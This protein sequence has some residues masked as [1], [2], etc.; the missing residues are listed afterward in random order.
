LRTSTL[1]TTAVLVAAGAS[2]VVV[3]SAAASRAMTAT[4]TTVAPPAPTTTTA[5]ATTTAAAAA[6]TTTTAG[7]T[8]TAAAAAP[9][10]TGAGATTTAAGATS[11]VAAAPTGLLPAGATLEQ[12]E[13]AVLGALGP[14]ADIAAELTPLVNAVPAGIP[15]PPDADVQEVSVY[16]YP[17]TTDVSS[18]WYSS[19][20]LVTSA[21]A[22]PDLLTFFQS[23][24]P[25]A[26]FVQTGDSVENE[27]DRQIRWLDYDVPAPTSAQDGVRVAIVDY[28]AP[29]EID[30]MQL[31]IDY[32]LDPAVT[33]IYSGWPG[34]LPLIE[35]V[36]V[37]DATMTT[38]N[39]GGDVTLNLSN[40]YSIPVAPT[41]AFTQFEAGLA[42]TGYSIDPDSD[43]AEGY[44]DI[45]GGPLG[46]LT[47]FLNE[48]FPEDTTRLSIDGSFDIVS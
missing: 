47:I 19:T 1:R 8:T 29:D 5:G 34:A 26:G 23:G 13:A 14:T 31:E 45:L 21:M 32:G 10:T 11:T 6:P 48:G 30:F 27:D 17:D 42:G 22:A 16:Y 15:T 40:S 9:T 37:E 24:L 7:A 33:Q 20:L 18:S 39:F 46:E 4:T 38:F 36:P 2:V 43:P 44:F 28:T 41:D 25:A 3:G 35:G 12:I